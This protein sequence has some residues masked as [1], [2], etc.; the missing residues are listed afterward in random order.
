MANPRIIEKIVKR[1]RNRKA[2]IDVPNL[3]RRFYTDY[4]AAFEKAERLI[5]GQKELKGNDLA[6]IRRRFSTASCSS[7]SSSAKDGSTSAAATTIFAPCT[8]PEA[9]AKNRSTAAGSARCSSRAFRSK[10]N[11]T[12]QPTDACRI[13]KA[14]K[15]SGTFCAQHPEGRSGKRCL[16]PFPPSHASGCSSGRDWT[17][18]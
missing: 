17:S 7:A 13:S 10:A 2:F 12:A 4:A 1:V 14:E 3:A 5:A 11:S 6:F 16:T 18:G 8:L 15:G 9:I